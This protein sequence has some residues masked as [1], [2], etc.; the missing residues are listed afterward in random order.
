MC[1]RIHTPMLFLILLVA[2]ATSAQMLPSDGD[3]WTEY[4]NLGEA[5]ADGWIIDCGL[6][7]QYITSSDHMV[8]SGSIGCRALQTRWC[9]PFG[10]ERDTDLTAAADL[11]FWHRSSW[12]GKQFW[13]RVY[14]EPTLAEIVLGYSEKRIVWTFD[15]TTDWTEF[16]GDID[17]GEWGW[18]DNLW[19]PT[20]GNTE[21]TRLIRIE[22]F[23]CDYFSI[24]IGDQMLVDGLHIVVTTTDDEATSWGQVKRLYR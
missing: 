13:V 1:S 17:D 12:D 23:Y 18:Y 24:A 11:E 2:T 15:T 7:Q 14:M 9:D 3:A 10:L 19:Q 22:W 5:T 20:G 6:S 4:A 16:S 8:G 21:L